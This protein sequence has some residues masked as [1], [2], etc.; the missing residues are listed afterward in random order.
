MFNIKYILLGVALMSSFAYSAFKAPEFCN[1]L[2]CPEYELI[3]S[4]AKNIEIRQYKKSSWVSTEM[5]NGSL[6][7]LRSKGF[8]TLYNYISGKNENK[9]K[10]EMS[11]PVLVKINS[12]IPFSDSDVIGTMSFYLGYKYENE[13]APEPEDSNAYLFTLEP[14]KYAVISYGGY[15]KQKDQEENLRTL[16]SYLEQNNYN[17]VKD[18]YFY[19]GYDSPFRF[20]GRHN[21]VWVELN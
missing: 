11:A 19:A 21:E 13:A 18:Y 4:P 15:S 14:K 3:S 6:D 9:E 12:K 17:F 8:W 2:E 20:F 10:I 7:S 5:K 1:G 16:G